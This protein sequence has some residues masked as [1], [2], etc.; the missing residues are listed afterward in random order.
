MQFT[1]RL[2]AFLFLVPTWSGIASADERFVPFR[3][4]TFSADVTCPVGHP[5]L[6]GLYANAQ[7]IVNPLLARGFVLLGPE[8]P[9]VL[10]AIDWCEIRNRSYDMWREGLAEA[11]ATRRER[12]LVCCLHQ[13][14]APLTDLDARDLLADVGLGEN[15]FD[16]KF[17]LD[18]VRRTAAALR[19]SLEQARRVTH[20]GVGKARVERVASNRRVMDPEGRVSYARGSNSGGDDFLRKAAD[21]LIDPWL[22][23]L[24]FWDQ[25]QPLLAMHAYATHPMSY[26]GKGGVSYDF[27][28]IARDLQQREHPDV[29]QIYVSGCSGDVTAGR[30]NDGSPAN[31]PLLAN[32]LYKA[33]QASFTSTE[34]HPL[35]KA[36]FRNTSLDLK[37]REGH[38]HSRESMTR[39][40]RDSSTRPRNRILAAM[41]LASRNRID[42]GQTIDFP[43]VDFGPARILLFPGEAF[44]G[45]QLLAQHNTPDSFVVSVG[46]GECWPGY[47][48]TRQG[49]ADRF[50][51]VWYW[52]GP[53]SDRRMEQALRRLAAE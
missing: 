35:T 4:A 32:R 9:I 8:E 14:D 30:Y 27:V 53:D 42:R 5:L 48:P 37:F 34:K 28:G 40:L 45:Y 3:I 50:E 51:N 21:G 12:V 11:A 47:I 2:T 18:C 6:G 13:H 24:S 36:D 17:E 23:T 44:V 16:A 39:V 25:D 19:D 52:V 1:T 20:I 43:C 29:F 22:R 38:S 41:G 49:F 10:C 46:Y 15:M 7:E 31:R 33:M 26:Y